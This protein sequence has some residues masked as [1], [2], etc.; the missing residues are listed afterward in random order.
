MLI[1]GVRRYLFLGVL[2]ACGAVPVA[3]LFSPIDYSDLRNGGEVV[4]DPGDNPEDDSNECT[5][6]DCDD[7]T[8][9][10]APAGSSCPNGICDGNGTCATCEDGIRNGN[11]VD[12]DCGGPD[13]P[14]CDGEL[15]T[16]EAAGCQSGHCVDGVCCST[17]CDKKC[18]SCVVTETGAPTGTC[19]PMM[20]GKPDGNLCNGLGGCGLN[21]LCACED[22][23]KDQ[24]ETS[25]DCGGACAGC[26]PGTPCRQAFECA[27]KSP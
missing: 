23:V 6:E 17:A 7:A 27:L 20:L 10:N 12:V 1:H 26:S 9:P 25:V 16:G 24:A 11:E 4:L 13:C 8:S 18:E 3:C 14:H 19:A 22:G 2:G 5:L 21:N 15:C